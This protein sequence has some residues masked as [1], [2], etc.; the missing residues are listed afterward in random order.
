MPLG[1][2]VQGQVDSTYDLR[3]RDWTAKMEV[4]N[5]PGSKEPE[6]G[7]EKRHPGWVHH[8]P[9]LGDRILNFGDHDNEVAGLA[10]HRIHVKWMKGYHYC[11]S[12]F[13]FC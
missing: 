2:F 12:Q 1:F 7:I 11:V 8:R 13:L 4:S 3:Q 5:S 9:C 6:R 10:E